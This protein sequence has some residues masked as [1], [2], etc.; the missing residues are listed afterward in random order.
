[1]TRTTTQ[2]KYIW[3]LVS[4]LAQATGFTREYAKE[5]MYNICQEI[6]GLRSSS[7][8]TEDQAARLIRRLEAHIATARK[9]RNPK[10]ETR[11][12]K[13]DPDALAT[14]A[15]L[16]T[17]DQLYLDVGIDT[18]ARQIAFCRRVVKSFMPITRADVAKIHEALEAM[19]VRQFDTATIDKMLA[20]AIR[21]K[22]RLTA[23]EKKFT[24]DIYRQVRANRKLSSMKCK[25]LKEIHNKIVNRKS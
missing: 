23:W 16:A 25:K 24:S 4:N 20:I 5:R 12:P 9:T 6:S 19:Y 13:H 3:K 10:P 18:E 8:L 2:N 1:M 17:L 21:N 15:Q 14:N 22:E 11:N 7:Q